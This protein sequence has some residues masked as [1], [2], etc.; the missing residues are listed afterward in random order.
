[1]VVRVVPDSPAAKAGLRGVDPSSGAMGDVIV[2]ANGVQVHRLADLTDQ[3]E[4]IGIGNEIGLK[5]QRDGRTIPVSV[6][7]EDTSKA[8]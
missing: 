4:K 1:M 2:G 5:V 3:I 6:G 8:S 7:V